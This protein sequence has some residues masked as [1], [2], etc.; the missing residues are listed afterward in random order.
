ML[1]RMTSSSAVGIS[2]RIAASTWSVSRAVSSMR[3]AGLGAQVKGELAA[4]GVREE[5]L[6][7]PRDQQEGDETDG[8]EHRDEDDAPV[9]HRREQP[10][11]AEAEPL[12]P[13]LERLL[14]AGERVSRGRPTLDGR[15]EQ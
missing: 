14:P 1:S 7:E 5:V 12:E 3:G 10:P 6:A 9:D 11:V 13:S 8:Q 4:V 15:R 2:R